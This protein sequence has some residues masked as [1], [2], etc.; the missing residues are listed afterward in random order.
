M[1]EKIE[2]EQQKIQEVYYVKSIDAEQ[3]TYESVRSGQTYQVSR[4]K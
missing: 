2:G 3:M 4:V 1:I